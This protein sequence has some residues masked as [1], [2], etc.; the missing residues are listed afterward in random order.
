MPERVIA[1]RRDFLYVATVSTGAVAV[2]AAIWPLIDA[3]NPT[4][5][6]TALSSIDVDL[7][8]VDI[9]T[10]ITV[11]WQGKP[12]FIDH[13]TNNRIALAKADDDATMPDPATDAER[14]LNPEW[15]IVI[16]VCTHLG[17]IPLGQNESDPHGNWKGWFCP[18]HGS[19]YDTAGRI[20]K[21]PAPRNL[22]LPPYA[23][24]TDTLVK[25]G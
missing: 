1:A 20:R 21:G 16:G 15:L 23:F 24:S 18:C 25:I 4:A 2:G 13:R 11:K 9:G 14:A 3:L 19:H 5:D 22:D 12:V 10:R 8:G 6:V 17:C 7:E